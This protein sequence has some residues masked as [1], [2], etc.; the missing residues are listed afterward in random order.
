[1]RDELA[2][3]FAPHDP[4]HAHEYI[5][6]T[7][8]ATL[9]GEWKPRWIHAERSRELVRAIIAEAGFEP[10][11]HPL[12]RAE[13]AN[14]ASRSGTSRRG[15]PSLSPGIGTSGTAPRRS[16]STGGCRSSRCR[17]PTP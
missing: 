15:S 2:R 12:R 3:L 17:R 13:T 5:D 4:E 10:E 16:R 7:E 8:M 14:L 9:L 11:L 1:M 6:P